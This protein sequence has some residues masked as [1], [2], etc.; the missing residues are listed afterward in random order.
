M[1]LA[2]G[3]LNS[4]TDDRVGQCLIKVSQFPEVFFYIYNSDML[5]YFLDHEMKSLE[6]NHA[7]HAIKSHFK[8]YLDIIQCNEKSC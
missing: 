7:I 6:Y 1:P 3:D 5:I 4:S 8:C 2:S